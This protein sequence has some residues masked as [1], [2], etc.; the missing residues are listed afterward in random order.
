M[1]EKF[2]CQ[3]G[4]G[5]AFASYE[6]SGD[7]SFESCAALC[8]ADEECKGFDFTEEQSVHPELFSANPTLKKQDSCRLYKTIKARQSM[9]SASRQF[10][11]KVGVE[12]ENFEVEYLASSSASGCQHSC[13]ASTVTVGGTDFEI[14]SGAGI[15]YQ[16]SADQC[17]GNCAVVRAGSLFSTSC[18]TVLPGSEK[19]SKNGNSK[20]C[21]VSEVCPST[22]TMKEPEEGL[23]EKF[24]C[25]SGQGEAFK[26]YDMTGDNS[27]EGCATLCD[28]DEECQAFDFTVSESQHPELLSFK[29]TVAK[30]DACRLY[31][32]NKPRLGDA[33]SS[34]RQY[35]EKKAAE[36][37]SDEVVYDQEPTHLG[38][39]QADVDENA[40]AEL[41][42]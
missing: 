13:G 22:T 14:G 34:E 39:E 1:S 12:E 25:Q 8:N 9:G 20:L 36:A 42:E 23:D 32:A 41:A 19:V 16:A 2:A 4:Q 31:K 33:G 37:G 35:C 10:C 28:D 26:A 21:C 29:P 5:A 7:N 24:A 6:Q 27:F 40:D 15:E 11:S 17:L 30:K 38:D 3:P 18:S